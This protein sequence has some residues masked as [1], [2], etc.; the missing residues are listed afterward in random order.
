MKIQT[1]SKELNVSSRPGSLPLRPRIPSTVSGQLPKATASRDSG[2][3]SP[4][5]SRTITPQ[6]AC[7][8]CGTEIKL[9]ESLAEPL[10][11]EARQH[12]KQ[13]L[14]KREVE[15]GER[16]AK[17]RTAQDELARAT[18][19]LDEKVTARLAADRPKIAE[20]EAR[21][22]RA[23]VAAEMASRDRQ[24]SELE[25]ALV[26][27]GQKLAEAQRI[28]AEVMRKERELDDARRELDLTSRSKFRKLSS[29]SAIKLGPRP[30]MP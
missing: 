7:P 28:Q 25:D 20:A 24:M 3:E 12:F 11:A 30:T 4:R 10:V 23:A 13:E 6:I 15:F 14:A 1:G 5:A 26:D 9:T 19:A 18:E 16:E 22:A 2:S 29:P 27:R 8:T 17:L 21:R